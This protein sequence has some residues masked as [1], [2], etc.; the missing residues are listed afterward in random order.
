MENYENIHR[1]LKDTLLA[2]EHYDSSAMNQLSNQTIHMAS[3]GDRDN[4]TVAILIYSLGKIY[5]REDYR[6]L[7][8][9]DTLNNLVRQSIKNAIKN[10][11]RKN[12]KGFRND[13]KSLRKTINK[14]SGKLKKYIKEIF[15][16]AHVNKA[17]RI[18]EHGI[19]AEKTAKMLGITLYDLQSYVGQTGIPEV[20]YNQT[21]GIKQR[22]K[23]LEELF[24]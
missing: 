20:K 21:I 8:G 11:E 9:W 5:S 23:M 6:K 12:E 10:I 19:S 2:I 18:Y 17:S 3:T 13:L 4:L 22:V 7:K 24:N 16:K 1:I 14:I 15:D